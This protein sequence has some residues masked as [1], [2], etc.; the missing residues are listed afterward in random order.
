MIS[1]TLIGQSS[2][3][4]IREYT[5]YHIGSSKYMGDCNGHNTQIS[6]HYISDTMSEHKLFLIQSLCLCQKYIICANLFKDLIS[7]HVSIIP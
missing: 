1:G 6:R 4:G 7:D 2:D 5:F 3:S